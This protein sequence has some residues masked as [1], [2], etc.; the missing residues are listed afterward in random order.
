ME[1]LIGLT[2]SAFQ[3]SV[4]QRFSVSTIQKVGIV[5]NMTASTVA[6]YKS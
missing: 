5:A 2:I 3:F 1:R 6:Q 4:F